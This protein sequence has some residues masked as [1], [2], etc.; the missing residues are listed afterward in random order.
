[1]A[2]AAPKKIKITLDLNLEEAMLV[3][4]GLRTAARTKKVERQV[5]RDAEPVV[6]KKMWDD[7]CA[8]E[9]LADLIAAR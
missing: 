5:I 7:A 4:D 6:A 1:M 3:V 2:K 9:Q 8:M